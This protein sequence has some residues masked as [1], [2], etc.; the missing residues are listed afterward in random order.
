MFTNGNLSNCVLSL[1]CL[2]VSALV[3]FPFFKVADKYELDKE[4]AKAA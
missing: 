1:L 4:T 2:A 3:W